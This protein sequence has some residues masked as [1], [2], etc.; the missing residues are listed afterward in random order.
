MF[1]VPNN[2]GTI[3][4][5]SNALLNHVESLVASEKGTLHLLAECFRSVVD[6]LLTATEGEVL[7]KICD[8]LSPLAGDFERRQQELSS[9]LDRQE[10]MARWLFGTSE[11][12]SWIHDKGAALW[13]T[14]MRKCRSQRLIGLSLTT[15]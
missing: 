6:N 11:F 1:E 10:G 7:M 13:C 15:V 14:G 12:K 8:W 4:S 2:V 9:T 5:S 3:L